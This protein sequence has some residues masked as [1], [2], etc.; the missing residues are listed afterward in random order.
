MDV[1]HQFLTVEDMEGL[2]YSQ[3]LCF[4]G[5]GLVSIGQCLRLQV[6][7]EWVNTNIISAIPHASSGPCVIFYTA[8]S[9]IDGIKEY[10]KQDP[11]LTRT[12]FHFR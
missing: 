1:E 7:M 8:R 6:P 3:W 2:S 4:N 11:S 10:C 12:H 5:L 9:K